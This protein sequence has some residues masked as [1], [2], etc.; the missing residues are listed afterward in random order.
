[1][2][3]KSL[4]DEQRSVQ[5]CVACTPP[6][7]H[8]KIPNIISEYLVHFHL[9]RH[10]NGKNWRYACQEYPPERAE[11][12]L[13]SSTVTVWCD[14]FHRHRTT[15]NRTSLCHAWQLS[16]SLNGRSYL[17]NVPFR[18]KGRQIPESY[19][20][21]EYPAE[22]FPRTFP[23]SIRRHSLA[24]T[25]AGPNSTW[26]ISVGYAKVSCFPHTPEDTREATVAI[27]LGQSYGRQSL[28]YFLG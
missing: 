1:M 5:K 15:R 19:Y 26:L 21:H 10:V 2:S 18:Q 6:W 23:F 16:A 8:T 3:G 7:L 17:R 22:H 27:W 20:F 28:T 11:S 4:P 25:V 14:T 13:S 9:L 24:T 12:L